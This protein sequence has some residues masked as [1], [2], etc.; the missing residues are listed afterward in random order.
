MVPLWGHVLSLLPIRVS[1]AEMLK[2]LCLKGFVAVSSSSIGGIVARKISEVA[3]GRGIWVLATLPC[4]PSLVCLACLGAH[5][6]P[7]YHPNPISH[8]QQ[9]SFC[10][11]APSQ[12]L[13]ILLSILTSHDTVTS[14]Q[15]GW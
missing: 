8:Q 14:K 4:V 11:L 10:F 15:D 1:Q 13:L 3:S 6:S 12:R 7:R 5:F 2:T 9:G